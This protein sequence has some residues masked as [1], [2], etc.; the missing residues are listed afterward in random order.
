MFQQASARI[1]RY[2][3]LSR[4]MSRNARVKQ[5]IDR[6]IQRTREQLSGALN[7]LIQEKP[8]DAISV[9]EVVKRADVGR[10]T[11]YSHY[12]G[13]EDLFLS[14]LDQFLELTA[15]MLVKNNDV[16]GR[17]V[18]LREFFAHVGENRRLYDALVSSGKIHD[19]HDLGQ[20]HFARSIGERLTAIP[21]ARHV[22]AARREALAHAFAGALLS[23][24]AWWISHD[25]P[26]SPRYM[27]D[28]YHRMVWDGI[29][30]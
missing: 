20:E 18:P 30:S 11:F 16:S 8:F 26:Q 25:M 12:R 5:K 2:R 24:L 15:T 22:D 28:I 19:F 14:D 29:G 7:G 3:T 23:L 9:Q 27:D 1:C 6:R 21:E 10:S 4:K 13:K 17:V